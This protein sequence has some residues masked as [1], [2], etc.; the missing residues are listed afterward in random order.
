MRLDALAN[1][2]G[3]EL[4]GDP[5]IEVRSV[6]PL[7]EARSGTIVVL[8]DP[9]QLARAEA[10]GAVLILPHDAPPT[11]S[12]SIRVRNARLAL[13]LALSALAPRPAPPAGIHP[14]CVL[15]ARVRMG[16]D[17]FLGPYACVG[18]EVTLGDRAQVHAHAVIEDD[19]RIGPECVLHPHATVRRGCALGARVV[20]QSGAVI[21]ADGFGYAQ[22][23]HRRHVLI[24]QLGRVVIEDDVEIGANT[25]VDRAVF[26]ATRIGRGTKIDNLVHVAHNVQIGEDVAIAAAVFIAG[27]VRIGNRVLIG[28]LVGIRDHVE[29]GD[30]VIVQGDSGVARNIEA[31]QM[32]GGHPA[33]FHLLQRRIEATTKRL[34]EIVRHL[35]D[36]ERRTR[37]L[38]G[39]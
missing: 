28:G 9:H 16:R 2:L 22:D 12:P 19:V 14:T 25:T 39:G 24:P 7:E 29:I 23:E 33:V 1:R 36:L 3:G 21:G 27:S 35:R 26:G 15:G 37:R 10:A 8:T 32:V 13:A 4:Q 6:V 30:D 11:R 5:A 31:G 38:E 20:V 17:V 18:S 34:P